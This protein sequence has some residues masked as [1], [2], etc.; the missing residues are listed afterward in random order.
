MKSLIFLILVL[1]VVCSVQAKSKA[2]LGDITTHFLPHVCAAECFT[3]E[4]QEILNTEDFV[5]VAVEDTRSLVQFSRLCLAE[6]YI[7]C[8]Q[9]TSE[10][11]EF[12]K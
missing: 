7:N 5:C 6:T 3:H 11:N 10:E 4:D 12:L 9:M 1:T 2:S 8:D